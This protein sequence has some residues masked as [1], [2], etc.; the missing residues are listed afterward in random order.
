MEKCYILE[1]TESYGIFPFRKEKRC[2]CR[3]FRDLDKV[4]LFL[5]NRIGLDQ[6]DF[7]AYF[8]KSNGMTWFEDRDKWKW[9]VTEHTLE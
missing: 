4:G 1:A 3:V 7:E 5:S 6:D 8:D 9:T 2:V